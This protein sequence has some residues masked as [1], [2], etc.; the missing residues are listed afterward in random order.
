MNFQV[1]SQSVTVNIADYS[2]LV[3]NVSARLAARQGFALATINL[4]HLVKLRRSA[5]F[6][7]AY[8]EQDLIAADGN[9]VVWF[10]RL[11]GRSVHLLPGSDV[12]VPLA[13]EAARAGVPVALVG[14]TDVTLQAA[15]AAL[16]ARVP[17]LDVAFCAAPPMEFDVDGAEADALLADLSR[18]KIGLCFL[19]LGAPKQEI[20]AARGRHLAPT[21]G[22]A[23]IGA[24]L[25]FLAGTELRAPVWMRRLSLEWLWRLLQNPSR[26]IPRYAACAALLPVLAADALKLRQKAYD[27]RHRA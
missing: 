8:V 4:D 19:A 2:Q 15:A 16:R 11:A 27:M 17:G 12:L 25:D 10:S 24:G 1:E 7:A 26:M 18:N 23:S 20:F 22:F 14:A 9:P 3:A 6:R 5:R 21:V 13:R